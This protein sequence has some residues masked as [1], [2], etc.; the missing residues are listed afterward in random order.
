ME[1]GVS[2]KMFDD[3]RVKRL[4]QEHNLR[5]YGV[6]RFTV[7]EIF[8]AGGKEG[9][10][11]MSDPKFQK[12]MEEFCNF[13][14]K[15]VEGYIDDMVECGLLRY[16]TENGENVAEHTENVTK[17]VCLLQNEPLFTNL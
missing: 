15:Y 11:S 14:F 3:K 9:R 12:K 13:S 6:F 7:D 10:V 8:S 16:C 1:Y 5:A 2:T 4:I 17:Y